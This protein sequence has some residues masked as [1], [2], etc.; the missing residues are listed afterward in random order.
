[1]LC[2]CPRCP[3]LQ[4]S[5]VFGSLGPALVPSTPGTTLTCLSGKA[6]RECAAACL[7][8][9]GC[10]G[11]SFNALSST[12]KWLPG[13]VGALHSCLEVCICPGSCF[14]SLTG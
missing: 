2:P 13:A 1:M 11:F 8:Q 3:V 9:I 6:E 4:T 7:A 10:D 5:V 14:F 12:S